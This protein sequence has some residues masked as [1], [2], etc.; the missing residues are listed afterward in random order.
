ME[1]KVDSY[2]RCNGNIYTTNDG[3]KYAKY[4]LKENTAYLRCA[5]NKKGCKGTAKLKIDSNLI[6]PYSVHNHG[7]EEYKS[8][9]YD[10]KTTC[11]K[12]AQTTRDSLRKI[13]DDE[14]RTNP[15][16]CEIS[17]NECES[18]MY[19]SRRKL[20]PRIPLT[21]SEFLILLPESSFASHYKFSIS[22]NNQTAVIFYSNQM[23]NCLSELNKVQ[24]DGTFY[25]VPTQANDNLPKIESS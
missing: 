3:F 10:L 5:L 1:F 13:F 19:R 15:F 4:K 8:E 23:I 6:Y 25:T 2:K 22:T 17:F 21:A 12:R 11:K 7:P 18:S 24:F 20:Q 14:T 16:A 9:V